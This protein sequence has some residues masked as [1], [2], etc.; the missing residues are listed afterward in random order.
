MRR[1]QVNHIAAHPEIAARKSHIIAPILQCHQ[2]SQ[3]LRAANFHAARQF[4]R[5]IG[6][7]FNRANAVNA[8]DGGNNHHII[9]LQQ[10]A[11][12]GV[13]HP[14]DLLIDIAFFFNIGVGARH[15]GFRLVI[16]IIRDEIL[17]RIFRKK[18]FELAVKLRCQRFIGRQHKGRALGA[19]DDLRHCISLAR[20]GHA[21][22]HLIA[23]F[24]G[25]AGDKLVNRL[26]LVA[27]RLECSFQLKG[28]AAFGFFRPVRPV[29]HKA[30]ELR[31][32]HSRLRH[33]RQ[34]TASGQTL[35]CF[36]HRANIVE[37]ARLSRAVRLC[38]LMAGG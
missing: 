26:R 31:F 25:N 17:D 15:I 7:A 34:F 27:R 35:L 38:R 29:R 2:I 32:A 13:A 11:R 14:V 37:P 18:A 4:Q 33:G 36:D 24:I 8:R 1:K 19:L 20:A 6:V 9:A 3:Q 30:G 16:I 10:S 22:Q 21:E 5:H 12:G 28:D 23:L